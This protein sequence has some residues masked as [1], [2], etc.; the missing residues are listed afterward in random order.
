MTVVMVLVEGL[1]MDLKGAAGFEEPGVRVD[2]LLKGFAV[3][4]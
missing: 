2:A 3:M 4:T 1:D